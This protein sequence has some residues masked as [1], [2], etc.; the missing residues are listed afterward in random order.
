MIVIVLI[1]TV[2]II[3]I[4]L[5]VICLIRCDHATEPSSSIT[6]ARMS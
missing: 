3:I 4:V 1:T 2:I 5:I 6:D